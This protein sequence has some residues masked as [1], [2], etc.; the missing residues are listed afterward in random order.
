MQFTETT[1]KETIETLKAL[2]RALAPDFTDLSAD[3]QRVI[4][5]RAVENTPLAEIVQLEEIHPDL[6]AMTKAR[7]DKVK[8]EMLARV[9]AAGMSADQALEHYA[10]TMHSAKL[11]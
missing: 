6:V 7:A 3:A 2:K 5:M 4:F 1:D 8:E 10:Q 9:R 11:R